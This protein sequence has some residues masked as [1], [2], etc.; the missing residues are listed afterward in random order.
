MDKIIFSE[1]LKAFRVGF[2][3]GKIRSSPF[4]KLN[5][6]VTDKTAYLLKTSF[7]ERKGTKCVI[8]SGMKITEGVKKCTVKVE[9]YCFIYSYQSFAFGMVIF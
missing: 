9:D 7:R 5:Y 6:T 4:H 2:F 3:V 8:D 1:S